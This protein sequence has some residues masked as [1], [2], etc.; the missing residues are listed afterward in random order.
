MININDI[1]PTV[2][3]ASAH[4]NTT[5][6]IEPKMNARENPNKVPLP[7]RHIRFSEGKYE[8]SDPEVI[9]RLKWRAANPTPA[10]KLEVIAETWSCPYCEKT[11][12]TKNKLNGHLSM[13]RKEEKE[14]E[15]AS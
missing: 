1:Q 15:K 5:I 11:Y 6:A 8:T 3:F 4:R 13:H 7:G 9:K 14:G 10:I 12:P 2:I